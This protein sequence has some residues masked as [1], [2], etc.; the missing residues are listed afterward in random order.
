MNLQ[1]KRICDR[2]KA[3]K[4]SITLTDK[5]KQFI[6]DQSYDLLY[7]ARPVKRFL[8]RH[9]ETYLAQ[10]VLEGKIADEQNVTI[11]MDSKGKMH[12]IE[13]L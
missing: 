6:V 7:G 3:R 2:L 1:I 13:S 8:Q 11:D 4:I 10:A 12:L 5:T 9:L